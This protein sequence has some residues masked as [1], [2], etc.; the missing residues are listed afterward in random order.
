MTTFNQSS[1]PS[2]APDAGRV[3]VIR[4][5]A[6][7]SKQNVAANDFITICTLPARAVILGGQWKNTVA[8]GGTLTC[9]LGKTSS[10]TLYAAGL[11]GNSV[12]GWTAFT[13]SPKTSADTF[14]DVGASDITVAIQANNAADVA[15][16]DV[17]FW[18]YLGNDG[19]YGA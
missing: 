16:M 14:V 9:D 17:M 4:G 7:F 11:S 6:D 18:G 5:R 12:A 3:F 19:F 8:E 13:T 2:N 10:A 15:V 1:G